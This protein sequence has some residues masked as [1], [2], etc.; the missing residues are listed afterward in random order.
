MSEFA[1]TRQFKIDHRWARARMSAYAD[2]ELT[3]SRR[4]RMKGHLARC[5]RCR[6]LLASL[7]ATIAAAKALPSPASPTSPS[8]RA[9]A[10]IA[11]LNG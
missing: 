1:D 2:G 6:Q 7:Q 5:E 8:D 4:E 10:V 11:R 9:A 3:G